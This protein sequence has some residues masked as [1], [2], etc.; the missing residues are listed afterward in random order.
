MAK[1]MKY[2]RKRKRKYGFAFLIDIPFTDENG[3]V[4][5]FA[6]TVKLPDFPNEKSAL[7]AAQKIRNDA[8]IG[9]QSGKLKRSLPTVNNLYKRKWDLLPMSINT[10]EK[11]DAIYAVLKPIY[12]DKKLSDILVADIQES[13]NTYAETHSQDAVK[14]M[15]TVWRQIYKCALMLGYEIS[16]KTAA[17]VLPKSKV[18]S[19][20]R[21]VQMRQEDFFTVLNGLL[22]YGGSESYDNRGIWFMLQIMYFTGCRPAEALAL[23]A[24][25]LQG[26]YIRIN[27]SVGSTSSAKRQIVPPKTE[28]SERMIPVAPDLKPILRDLKRWSHHEYLLADESGNLRDI[29]QVSNQI[30][31]VARKHG[32]QFNAY[33]LRHLM[34]TELLHRGDS[35]VARDLLGHTSFSMTLDYARSTDQDL[36][37]AVSDLRAEKQPKKRRLSQPETAALRQ[38]L[39]FRFAADARFLAVLR[40]FQKE[41]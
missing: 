24:D 21:N 16:D 19:K 38:Y 30:H 10:H 29:D 37:S 11:Q 23:T 1:N 33:M 2:I 27:K 39:I 13:L 22:E 31:L 18:V 4:K 9:I 7:L 20:R 41:W 28:S 32:V 14:R 12:G 26:D 6:E 8:L 40:A 25:D 36:L 15:L 5:H 35:V 17:I 34:S 3:V